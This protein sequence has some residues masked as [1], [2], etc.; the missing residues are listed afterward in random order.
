MRQIL[1]PV[2]ALHATRHCSVGEVMDSMIRQ[3]LPPVF[4]QYV[5]VDTL[6]DSHLGPE[7]YTQLSTVDRCRAILTLINES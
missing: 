4:S 7:Q 5:S 6:T 1:H 2:A 3:R